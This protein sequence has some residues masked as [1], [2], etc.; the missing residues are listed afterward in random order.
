VHPFRDDL[1]DAEQLGSCL[2]DVEEQSPTPLTDCASNMADRSLDS[3]SLLG[4]LSSAPS[5]SSSST[6]TA[7]AGPVCTTGVEEVPQ[8]ENRTLLA[9]TGCARDQSRFAVNQSAAAPS[10]TLS[11]SHA[12]APAA[13]PVN[14]TPEVFVETAF[15]EGE[16]ARN[17]NDG[18]TDLRLVEQ[19]SRAY[20]EVGEVVLESVSEAPT[21]GSCT[22]SK[23]RAC[24][25]SRLDSST[26]SPTSR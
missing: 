10:S 4:S 15:A 22:R 19:R 13:S 11:L 2:I 17:R 14:T 6:S 5:S 18:P 20:L 24:R 12:A 23:T 1:D 9:R 8:V 26:T 7:G 25:M 16:N 21:R 3:K